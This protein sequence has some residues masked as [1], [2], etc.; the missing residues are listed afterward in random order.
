MRYATT[1]RGMTLVEML[2]YVSVVV[3]VAL[4]AIYTVFALR[5]TFERNRA[6]RQLTTAATTALERMVRDI[7]DAQ[8]LGLGSVLDVSPGTL[9]LDTGLTPDVGFYLSGNQVYVSEGGSPIGP[10]TPTA[11]S[12]D[13][14]IFWHHTQAG[15]STDLVRVGLT[16][17]LSGR[18]ATTTKTFYTSAVMRNSYE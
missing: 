8:G 18:F 10:L 3:I 14:L 13:A 1:K 16:L 11:V 15:T 5:E 12:A 6:E 9:I 17:S 7:R 4:A 2:I